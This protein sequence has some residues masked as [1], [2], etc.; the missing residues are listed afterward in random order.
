MLEAHGDWAVSSVSQV[1]TL[2]VLITTAVNTPPESLT[3]PSEGSSP[4][5]HALRL[6]DDAHGLVAHADAVIPA[7]V[8]INSLFG[9][10]LPSEIK[11]FMASL[12]RDSMDPASIAAVVGGSAQTLTSGAQCTVVDAGVM[13]PQGTAL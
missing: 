13:L 8:Q 4:C 9:T 6:V 2:N 11:G 7:G 3:H 10:P 5:P 1:C 12:G